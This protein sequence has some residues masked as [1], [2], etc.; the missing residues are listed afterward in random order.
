MRKFVMVVLLFVVASSYADNVFEYPM[1]GGT[2]G[3]GCETIVVTEGDRTFTR[4][5]NFNDDAGGWW[6]ANTYLGG[7]V[8]VSDALTFEADV[9]WHQEGS[10]AYTNAWIGVRIGSPGYGDIFIDP[11]FIVGSVPPGSVGDVWYHVGYD[12]TGEDPVVLQHMDGFEFFGSF[13]DDAPTADYVD[14]DS[15]V[16][17]PEPASLLL[18]GLGFVAV[19][20]RR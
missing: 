18:L 9:R 1:D 2:G 19:I 12:L 6:Y 7:E 11:L 4:G 17:T 3:W 16:F 5:T 8:D 20:R 14:M 13:E 15:V 10:S